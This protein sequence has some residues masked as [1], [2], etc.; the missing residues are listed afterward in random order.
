VADFIED[1]QTARGR[2]FDHTERQLANAAATWVRCYNARCQLD[3][4][5]RRG[6]NPP[7][8]SFIDQLRTE[9][10]R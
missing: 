3:N 9:Q 6:L 5:H 1:Y 4:Q 2:R 10:G 8:G 7:P